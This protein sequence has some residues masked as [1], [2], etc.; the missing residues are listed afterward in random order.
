MHSALSNADPKKSLS[1]GI[2][3]C[4]NLRGRFA[5]IV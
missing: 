2:Y 3:R 1:N 5:V 4:G